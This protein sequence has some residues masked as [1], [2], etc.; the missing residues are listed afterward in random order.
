M[1]V[2]WI[3]GEGE[4][5]CF[6]R[7]TLNVDRKVNRKGSRPVQGP[8]LMARVAKPDQKREASLKAGGR[9]A[10]AIAATML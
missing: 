9:M 1:P 4:R 6:E 2:A 3:S 7:G 5:G 8:S 10:N